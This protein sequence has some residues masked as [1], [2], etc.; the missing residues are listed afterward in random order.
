MAR[1]P[2]AGRSGRKV[3]VSDKLTRRP[4]AFL[5]WSR[6]LAAFAGEAGARRS[7]CELQVVPKPAL[8]PPGT[9]ESDSP[10]LSVPPSGHPTPTP[11]EGPQDAAAAHV[12][13]LLTALLLRS[14]DGS[15]R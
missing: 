15:T 6:R 11:N 1:R 5:T 7:F 14:P 8:S 12:Q 10:F 4:D 13:R 9:H 3:F 2:R